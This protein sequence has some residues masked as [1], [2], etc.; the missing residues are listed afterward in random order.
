MGFTFVIMYNALPWNIPRLK[1]LSMRKVK[2]IADST[3]PKKIWINKW[4]NLF[5]TNETPCLNATAYTCNLYCLQIIYS[6]SIK[7]TYPNSGI[8]LGS[9][10][11]SVEYC[12]LHVVGTFV[13]VLLNLYIIYFVFVRNFSF[14]ISFKVTLNHYIIFKQSN[15]VNRNIR[16]DMH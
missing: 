4:N 10:I 2:L 11:Y 1:C 8:C 14:C 5:L 9:M 13:F 6:D 16:A 3:P 12:Y 15:V 7:Y